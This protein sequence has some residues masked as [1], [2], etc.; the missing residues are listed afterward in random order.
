MPLPPKT[1]DIAALDLFLSVAELG[2]VGRAAQA[3]RI[4][5]P[6]A[7]ARLSRLERQLGVVLLVRDTRGSTLTPAGE[8]V[9]GWS[10][11]VIE[12]AATLTDGAR[13]LREVGK[14][15]L[16]VAASLTVAEYLM[17]AWMLALR[18]RHPDLEIAV[19]VEN[20]AGV[21]RR[22]REN[23][24]DVGFIEA[25]AVPGDLPAVRVGEDELALVVAPHDPLAGRVA[26]SL[27]ARELAQQPL[28]LR[29]AGSGTRETFLSALAASLGTDG[30]VATPA[31]IE[32]GST[33][34]IVATA[35]AGGGVG[36]VSERAVA[37]GVRDGR[38]VRLTVGDLDLSR[39]LHALWRAEPGSELSHE[40][41]AL[42]KRAS[43]R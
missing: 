2:S 28:L 23:S 21:V 1:P 40:L 14:A 38:L 37:D 39:P 43:N 16:R 26:A 10:R 3:H 36:V 27:S 19:T 13:S 33:A 25:P 6:S 31:A 22:V 32:L 4:S 15:R 9:A 30:E 34:I 12:A 29:E 24:V 5:Q 18:R 41:V 20:S 35:L 11:R 8:I 7:S 42:A 17:P